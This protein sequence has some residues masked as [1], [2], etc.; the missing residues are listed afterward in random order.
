MPAA[1]IS[2]PLAH[3]RAQFLSTHSRV[4]WRQHARCACQLCWQGANFPQTARMRNADGIRFSFNDMIVLI[5]QRGILL[6]QSFK[7]NFLKEICQLALN[8]KYWYLRFYQGLNRWY[9]PPNLQIRSRACAWCSGCCT[10][11]RKP[12]NLHKETKI[13]VIFVWWQI[14]DIMVNRHSYSYELK[15]TEQTEYKAFDESWIIY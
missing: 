2:A 3:E 13:T 14:R 4:G 8:C 10:W 15:Q 7:R 1:H 12:H 9:S 5:N 11:S 6:T